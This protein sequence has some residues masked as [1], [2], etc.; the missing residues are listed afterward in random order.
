MRTRSLKPVAAILAAIGS[1]LPAVESAASSADNG[2][3]S[4]NVFATVDSSGLY[5]KGEKVPQGEK[6]VVKSDIAN[7]VGLR[8]EGDEFD[9]FDVDNSIEVD[10]GSAA[11]TVGVWVGDGMLTLSGAASIKAE[12][13]IRGGNINL[14][15]HEADYEFVGKLDMGGGSIFSSGKNTVNY[16]GIGDLVTFIGYAGT[17]FTLGETPTTQGETFLRVGDLQLAAGSTVTVQGD[18]PDGTDAA[19]DNRILAV[20]SLSVPTWPGTVQNAQGTASIRV[21][22]EGILVL[23][24]SLIEGDSDK[25]LC[26]EKS[27]LEVAV[28]GRIGDGNVGGSTLIMGEDYELANGFSIEVGNVSEDKVGKDGIHIGG[29]GRLIVYFEDGK[30]KVSESQSAVL[31]AISESGTS[32]LVTVDKGASLVLYQWDGTS[33]NI[34]AFDAE[35]VYAFGGARVEVDSEGNAVRLWCKDIAGLHASAIVGV[36]EAAENSGTLSALPGYELIK[37]TL[38]EEKVGRDVYANMV[39]GA[40]FLPVTSGLAT[41]AERVLADTVNTIMAHDVSLFEGKGHWWVDGKSSKIKADRIFSGGSGSFG[42]D[43]DVT[44]ATLGYDFALGKDWVMTAAVSFAG[45]DVESRG[46]ISRTTGDMSLATFAA[47]AARNF[48]NFELRFGLAY[49]RAMGDSHQLLVKHHVEADT[50]VDFVVAAA[51]VTGHSL[52]DMM[53]LAPYAQLSVTAARMDDEVITDNSTENGVSGD[54]FDTNAEDRVWAT[55]EAG[56]DAAMQFEVVDG[57]TLKPSLGASVRT[58]FGQTDWKIQSRLFDG[59]GLSS[60][61]YESA[62]TFGARIRAGIELASSGWHEPNRWLFGSS[63]ASSVEPYA[64]KVILQGEY[65][66]ASSGENTGSMSLQFRQLF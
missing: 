50:S 2:E 22:D 24:T 44:A 56:A 42:F 55:L 17:S 59:K 41:A 57:Y 65:E 60:A 46:L 61:V 32:T 49:S 43:A 34:G 7:S 45:I 40:V 27:I 38:A 51:R 62:Q 28:D 64:W 58:S 47:S 37:D 5:L 48:E 54:A 52:T 25:L 53:H 20:G 31:K 39:D 36:V 15:S 14:S 16:V 13:A 21:K 9:M 18:R 12:T 6:L 4:S 35:N 23:G 63:K 10:F 26:M 33:F 1:L 19:V 30:S 3:S 8:S 11:D 66:A 29:D